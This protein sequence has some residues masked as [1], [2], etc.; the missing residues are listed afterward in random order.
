MKITKFDILA[1]NFNFSAN[2]GYGRVGFD[3]DLS[4]NTITI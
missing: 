2:G 3:I 1:G 4:N